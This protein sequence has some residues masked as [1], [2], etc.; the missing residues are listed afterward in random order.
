MQMVIVVGLGVLIFLVGIL[1]AYIGGNLLLA[2]FRKPKPPTEES[3]RRFRERLL[4]PRWD[5]LQEHFGLPIPGPLKNLYEQT[6]LLTMQDLVFYEKRG[7]E[8]HALRSTPRTVTA[9]EGAT[10]SAEFLEF[11]EII[12]LLAL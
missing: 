3:I 5:E 12:G 9:A 1:A 6:T 7:K 4:N 10:V 11:S 2:R 8:W